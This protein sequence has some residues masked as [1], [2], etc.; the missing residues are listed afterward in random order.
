VSRR[1]TYCIW[2]LSSGSDDVGDRYGTGSG[3]RWMSGMDG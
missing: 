2:V 3:M 1:Q